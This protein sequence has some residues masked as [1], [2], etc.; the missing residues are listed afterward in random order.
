MGCKGRCWISRNGETKMV[1]KSE[2]NSYKNNGWSLSR[3]NM[4][5]TMQDKIW[6]R[7][8]GRELRVTSEELDKYIE[9]GYE[10]GRVKS[11]T[12]GKKYVHKDG[13]SIVID[14]KFI[15]VYISNGWECGY[16]HSSCITGKVSIENI[17]DGS[18]I[19][20]SI[21]DAKNLL[22]TGEYKYTSSYRK[23]MYN[24]CNGDMVLVYPK[25][26]ESYKSNGYV[27]GRPLH[28]SK[29]YWVHD[30][31]LKKNKRVSHDE[32]SEYVSQGWIRGRGN[33]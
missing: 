33:Y 20:C 8:D 26:I 31:N 28:N 13:K 23:H 16:A 22:L 32:L 9:N 3:S 11:Y 21:E 18:R 14:P 6:V 17:F 1:L 24:P 2:L 27:M 12:S 29:R 19:N 15:D 25:D 10:R 5:K 4:H 7:K 30:D